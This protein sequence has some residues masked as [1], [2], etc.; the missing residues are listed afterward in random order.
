[1]I[2]I[3]SGV[4]ETN[5]SSTHSIAVR[6][7]MHQHITS[8]EEAKREDEDLVVKDGYIVIESDTELEFGWGFDIFDTFYKRLLYAIASTCRVF[9]NDD[10]K[11]EVEGLDEIVSVVHEIFPEI[12]GIKL[13]MDYYDETKVS[14]GYVDHQSYGT[15]QEFVNENDM[16]M[17]EFLANKDVMLIIDND[18]SDHFGDIVR[19][20]VF[21]MDAFESCEEI[22][23]EEDWPYGMV[24]IDENG[25]EVR[26]NEDC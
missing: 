24:E 11:Y 14:V 5:S 13:P 3:R 15:Y 4:F 6:N 23:D 17:K 16:S 22:N 20:G 25:R 19:S 7:G 8:I 9:M 2:K 1:M 21:N 10:D 26:H 18:N 12:V